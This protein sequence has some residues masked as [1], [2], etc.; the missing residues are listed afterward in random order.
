MQ[1][2]HKLITLKKGAK[3]KTL[4]FYIYETIND[5]PLFLEC[6]F[7]C[8]YVATTLNTSRG[9]LSDIKREV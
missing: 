3:V 2:C 7:F 9:V 5:R 4:E 8:F 1:I 6:R